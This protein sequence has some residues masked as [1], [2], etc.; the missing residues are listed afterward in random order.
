MHAFF[1]VAKLFVCRCY[2]KI[3][4]QGCD[5]CD[6]KSLIQKYSFLANFYQ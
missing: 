3:K 4:G 2:Q 5:R 1:A 6:P